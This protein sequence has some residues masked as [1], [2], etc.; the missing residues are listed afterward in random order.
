MQI[1]ATSAKRENP[2]R[3]EHLELLENSELE[4]MR[5]KIRKLEQKN[6][7]LEATVKTN[8]ELLMFKDEELQMIK[9][10]QVDLD[11]HEAQVNDVIDFLSALM[12]NP[13]FKRIADNLLSLLDS[14]S[15]NWCREV[16]RSWKDFLDNEWSMLQLQIFHLKRYETQRDDDPFW[17]LLNKYRFNFKP[18]IKIMEKTTN[19]S[20]LRVFIQMCREL[21][22]KRCDRRLGEDPLDY[23]IDHH[24]HQELEMLLHCPIQKNSN[25]LYCGF[26]D[27]TKI[28]KYA[29]L[30]IWL[31]NMC[32]ITFGSV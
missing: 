25:S 28:F 3:P 27:F 11:H 6:F 1:M 26:R 18:L 15:F 32:K 12:N 30:S 31:R 2:E 16:C 7:E 14:K 20:K 29:C 17:P 10:D 23:M 19:K 22:S 4:V 5:A 9:N 8:E 13:G 24:R 21:V